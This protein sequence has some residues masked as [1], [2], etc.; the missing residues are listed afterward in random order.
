M[1][2]CEEQLR[3]TYAKVP[4]HFSEPIVR[5]QE[6]IAPNWT[7]SVVQVTAPPVAASQAAL[8]TDMTTS[9]HGNVSRGEQ[10]RAIAEAEHAAKAA[11]ASVA[12]R[13]ISGTATVATSGKDLTFTMS[14]IPMPLELVEF[15]ERHQASSILSA[16][17][18][19]EWCD[20]LSSPTTSS[21][22]VDEET[23]EAEDATENSE[24]DAKQMFKEFCSV[25][26]KISLAKRAPGQDWDW[27]GRILSNSLALAFQD[28]GGCNIFCNLVG[29]EA[30][31]DPLQPIPLTRVRD[32]NE[33]NIDFL[34]TIDD[35]AVSCRFAA[36]EKTAI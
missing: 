21:S 13:K 33:V 23:L 28:L 16:R 15:L 14:V 2:H 36:A 1:K 31:G 26:E 18:L 4:F 11:A 25:L 32:D 34:I 20:K 29:V 27:T 35:G 8:P 30:K 6:T 3:T 7:P 5:F 12:T 19:V 9:D 10:Q 24:D 22:E 17:T